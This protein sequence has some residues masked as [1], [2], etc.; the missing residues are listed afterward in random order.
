VA[1][2]RDDLEGRLVA[3]T[4][5]AVN[6]AA[7]PRSADTT[8]LAF[9]GLEAEPILL[10]LSERGVCASAGAA[11]ASGSVEP[12]PV[13]LALGVPADLAAGSIRF[14]LSRD[15]TPQDIDAAVETV[16][17]VVQRLRSA[18]LGGSPR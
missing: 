18:V 15:T 5:A 9:A 14:S 7:A 3:S 13:L 17:D 4:G 12:S 8:S 6:G 11:C 16:S 2:L 10:S 1:R